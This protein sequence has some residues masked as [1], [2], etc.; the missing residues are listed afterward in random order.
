M[1]GDRRKS[2]PQLTNQPLFSMLSLLARGFS[3]NIPCLQSGGSLQSLKGRDLPIYLPISSEGLQR[4]FKKCVSSAKVGLY[5]RGK[6]YQ[7]SALRKK[8]KLPSFSQSWM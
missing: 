2:M 4:G 3:T 7:L 8:L 5:E 1:M 6:G